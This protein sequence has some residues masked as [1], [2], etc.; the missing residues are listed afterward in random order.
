MVAHVQNIDTNEAFRR[1]RSYARANN[2]NLHETAEAVLN[3][4]LTI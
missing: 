2:R 3:R 4:T 1:L